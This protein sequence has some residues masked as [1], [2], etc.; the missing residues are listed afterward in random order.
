MLNP[1]LDVWVLSLVT[2][3]IFSVFV[4]QRCLFEGWHY[5]QK[6]NAGPV[7]WRFTYILFFL[8]HF[9]QARRYHP[10]TLC[11]ILWYL[12]LSVSYVFIFWSCDI[13]T[14]SNLFVFSFSLST[15]LLDRAIW[16]IQPSLAKRLWRFLSFFPSPPP[17]LPCM[18]LKC[19]SISVS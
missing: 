12:L 2:H 10:K 3:R 17:S 6:V 16:G 4:I 7:W 15:E 18:Y 5:E 1:S 9:G 14:T 19:D 13:H 8:S 11:D